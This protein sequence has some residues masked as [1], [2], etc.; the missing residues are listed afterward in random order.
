[1]QATKKKSNRFTAT[2]NI[3]T[4]GLQC[5]E[6]RPCCTLCQVS[7]KT[8]VYAVAQL[9]PGPSKPGATSSS[10]VPSP[11]Q[12]L[13]APS[14]C[15]PALFRGQSPTRALSQARPNGAVTNLTNVDLY[16]HFVNHACRTT[17]SWH[18]DRIVMQV[19]IAKI[20]LD[21]E[22]VSHSILALS[23]ACL[24]RDAISTGN[25]DAATVGRILDLGLQHH[26]LALEQMRTMVS[27]PRDS[28]TQ[29]LLA[30][31]L[32]LV[33]FAFAFQQIQHW[34]LNAKGSQSTDPVTPRDA[35]LLLRGIGTTIAVLNFKRADRSDENESPKAGTPW[36]TIF[37]SQ[38]TESR[39]CTTVPECSHTM[40]P[41][42]AATFHSA[43]S[44]LQSKIDSAL[45]H[46]QIDEEMASILEAYDVL[47]DL[48]SS[49]FSNSPQD[50]SSSEYV[51]HVGISFL[52]G[53]PY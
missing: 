7:S 37:S 34:V 29:P 40:F 46:P 51:T 42:L 26:T 15:L 23:A 10:S 5:D 35:I 50:R 36:N 43:L 12:S 22:P 1:M 52:V 44:Q 20:A 39:T 49:T 14:S 4:K 30:I 48:M 25:S 45:A 28:E 19:G 47:N 38:V 18:K 17:P 8:C 2:L 13:S 16:L 53:R 24:C 3:P 9:S 11:A 27:R 31:A 21:S 32:L 33:P 6:K 41:V